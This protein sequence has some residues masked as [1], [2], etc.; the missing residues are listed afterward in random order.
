MIDLLDNLIIHS[1][2]SLGD[3]DGLQFR[4]R[5]GKSSMLINVLT[6]GCT[7]SVIYELWYTAQPTNMN[8]G[9]SYE[10]ISN[11]IDVTT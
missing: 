9:R 2:H 11:S 8:R 10:I 1:K 5:K 7:L 3:K 4:K 6:G